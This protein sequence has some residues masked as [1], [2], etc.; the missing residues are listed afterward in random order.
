MSNYETAANAALALTKS[1]QSRNGF[2]LI[3]R[4]IEMAAREDRIATVSELIPRLTKALETWDTKLRTAPV[5]WINRIIKGELPTEALHVCSAINVAAATADHYCN[6]HYEL[7]AGWIQEWK[8]RQD[9]PRLMGLSFERSV[10]LSLSF[11]ADDERFHPPTIWEAREATYFWDPDHLETLLKS[12]MFENLKVLDLSM[13]KSYYGPWQSVSSALDGRELSLHGIFTAAPTVTHLDIS[14][15]CASWDPFPIGASSDSLQVLHMGGI[16]PLHDTSLERL[17]KACPNVEELSVH[18]SVALYLWDDAF[19]FE[20]SEYDARV[21]EAWSTADLET[22]V[23]TATGVNAL[24]TLGKL[25]SLCINAGYET[26][27]SHNFEQ[28]IRLLNDNVDFAAE[29]PFGT[30]SMWLTHFEA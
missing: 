17:S 19:S 30:P 11:E 15:N 16:F 21:W 5:L 27:Y 7:F 22:R 10:L 4:A 18:S 25:K 24:N 2:V 3:T 26:E 1:P 28:A 6:E 20:D 12:P 13:G 8:E 29:Q 9:A 14:H 23:L